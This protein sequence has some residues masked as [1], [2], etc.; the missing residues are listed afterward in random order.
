MGSLLQAFDWA[1]SIKFVPPSLLYEFCPSILPKIDESLDSAE[2]Y[3]L[4]SIF[5]HLFG[6]Q[7]FGLVAPMVPMC[8]VGLVVNVALFFVG[9]LPTCN[10]SES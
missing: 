10:F 3:S 5:M 2:A 6:C 7:C 8:D 1:P 4:G 9:L